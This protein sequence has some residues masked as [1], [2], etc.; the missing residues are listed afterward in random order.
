MTLRRDVAGVIL[1]A[2]LFSDSR[3]FSRRLGGEITQLSSG[4][5]ISGEMSAPR[6]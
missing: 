3:A 4:M 1:A 6:L 2:S 5:W